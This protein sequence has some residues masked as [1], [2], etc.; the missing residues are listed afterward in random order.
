MTEKLE[1]GDRVRVARIDRLF[2]ELLDPR[3]T[4]LWGLDRIVVALGGAHHPREP[5]L[6]G[7]R[8]IGDLLPHGPEFE[9]P[10]GLL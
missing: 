3:P 7:S 10:I 8:E 9:V 1:A 2:R 5:P 6:T 4:H